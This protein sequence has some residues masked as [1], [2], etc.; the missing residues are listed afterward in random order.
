MLWFL[1]I[2]CQKSGEIIFKV[3]S[4]TTI[5]FAKFSDY[6][7][8]PRNI[9]WLIDVIVGV[10]YIPVDSQVSWSQSYD[11]CSRLERFYVNEK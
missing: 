4:K 9:I 11:F 6:N 10:V 5:F 7:I 2:F 3:L 8:D 1:N